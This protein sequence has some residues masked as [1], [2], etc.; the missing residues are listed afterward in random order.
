MTPEQLISIWGS[1]IKLA[2]ALGLNP[3]VAISWFARGSIPAKHHAN[4][5]NAALSM[6]HVITPQDLFDV[7]LTLAAKDTDAAVNP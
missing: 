2:E 1:R 7:N 4:I 3:S 5:I 6:G